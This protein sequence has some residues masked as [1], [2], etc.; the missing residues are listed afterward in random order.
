MD[1]P[2]PFVTQAANATPADPRL[3]PTPDYGTLGPGSD[4]AGLPSGG[5]P[6]ASRQSALQSAHLIAAVVG[7]VAALIVG[8]LSKS[9][10][11]WPGSAPSH[12]SESGS[13]RDLPQLDQMKP[14]KQAET[15]LELAVGHSQGAV[16]QISS[17]V[18]R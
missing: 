10:P 5:A 9:H 17:R 3:R 1:V 7:M 18:D 6:S 11:M 13:A 15:L 4:I 14:Q 16:E 2:S 12:S 8:T